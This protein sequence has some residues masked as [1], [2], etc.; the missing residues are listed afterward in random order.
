MW[1]IFLLI[2]VGMAASGSQSSHGGNQDSDDWRFNRI[3]L[4]P[5]NERPLCRCGCVA[6]DDTWDC[7]SSALHGRQYFKCLELVPFFMVWSYI[8][9]G[10]MLFDVEI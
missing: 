9:F 10:F 3:L 5:W 8:C 1:L 2:F 7:N 6:I 4:P